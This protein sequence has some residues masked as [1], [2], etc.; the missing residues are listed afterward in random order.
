LLTIIFQMAAFIA[1]NVKV[2]R[3][4]HVNHIF[5]FEWGSLF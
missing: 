3:Q 5:L 1:I 2:F 4:I